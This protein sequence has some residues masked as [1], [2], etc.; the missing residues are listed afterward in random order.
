MGTNG[1]PNNVAMDK[2]G[3]NKAAFDAVNAGR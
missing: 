1:Y 2:S 3:V